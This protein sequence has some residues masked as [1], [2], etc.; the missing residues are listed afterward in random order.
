MSCDSSFAKLTEILLYYHKYTNKNRSQFTDQGIGDRLN[1]LGQYSK[2][3]EVGGAGERE[4]RR[5][6][7]G[8]E[9]GGRETYKLCSSH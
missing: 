8:E 9:V 3:E 1:L 4:R 5:E 7:K 6:G 2:I